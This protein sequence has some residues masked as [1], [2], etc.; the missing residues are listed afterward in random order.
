MHLQPQERLA[1]AIERRDMPAGGVIVVAGDEDAPAMR[2]GAAALGL[3]EGLW[4]NG[5]VAPGRST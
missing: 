2:T 1:A 5:T 4:D 3:I